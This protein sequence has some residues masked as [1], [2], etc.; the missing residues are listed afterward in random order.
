[1]RLRGTR[2]HPMRDETALEWVTT[3]TVLRRLAA[4][5]DQ[6]AWS[7]LVDRFRAPIERFARRQGLSPADAEDAAQETL[8]AFADA[9]RK[10]GYDRGK[11]RL[12]QWLFGIAWRRI[13][14]VRRRR[15]RPGAEAPIG[16]EATAFWSQVPADASASAAWDEDWAR[17]LLEQCLRKI[18]REAQ[19]STFRVC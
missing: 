14:H 13:D 17:A 1:S 7:A 9:Y 6:D 2:A 19:P 5:S 10:G 8:L 4:P 11:G 15:D 16:D 18:R 12:S 3:S